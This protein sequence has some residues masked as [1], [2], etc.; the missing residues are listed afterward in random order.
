MVL[1]SHANVAE[2]KFKNECDF[3]RPLVPSY[4]AYAE[5]TAAGPYSSPWS[6]TDWNRLA[7]DEL[8][9]A[10]HIVDKIRRGRAKNVIMFLG[11]GMG[12]PTVAAARVY[13]AQIRNLKKTDIYLNWEKFPHVG[14]SRVGSSVIQ[15]TV[16]FF[17]RYHLQ[18]VCGK[19]CKTFGTGTCYLQ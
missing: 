9:A 1:L 19:N 15:R 10:I 8:D 17:S 2:I 14:L 7:Q 3:L 4:N 5:T 13:Q 12:L 18:R 16:V 6:D 11:D